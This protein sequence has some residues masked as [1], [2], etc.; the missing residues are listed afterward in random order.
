MAK[1]RDVIR[2]RNEIK[3]VWL[4]QLARLGGE[5]EGSL[6]S[7][8]ALPR[9]SLR[10][11]VTR[12]PTKTMAAVVCTA[13]LVPSVAPPQRRTAGV[14]SRGARSGSS[15]SRPLLRCAAGGDDG[16]IAISPMPAEDKFEDD[17]LPDNLFDAVGKSAKATVDAI[18]E[19]IDGS[20]FRRKIRR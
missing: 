10:S 1:S 16:S 11:A 19:V 12:D 14:G 3:N 20:S 5:G 15:A 8:T 2:A 9:R 7:G 6:G 17:E 13:S 4:L 18:E